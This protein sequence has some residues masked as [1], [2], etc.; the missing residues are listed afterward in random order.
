MTSQ[1]EGHNDTIITIHRIFRHYT[2]AEYPVYERGCGA[3][4]D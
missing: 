1:T 3:G 2:Y 4:P